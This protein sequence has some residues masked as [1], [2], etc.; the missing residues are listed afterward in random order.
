MNYFITAIAVI[1]L[2]SAGLVG[3]LYL[4]PGFLLNSMPDKKVNGQI[5]SDEV[6]DLN[7]R[8]NKFQNDLTNL[9]GIIARQSQLTENNTLY[10]ARIA[11]LEN[12]MQVIK[13]WLENKVQSNTPDIQPSPDLQANLSGASTQNFSPELFQNPEFAKL[14]QNKVEESLKSIQQKQREDMEKRISE[15]TQKAV[16]NRIEEFAKAQNLN[17]YQQQELNKI[18]S[19]RT[20]KTMELFNKERTQEITREEVRTKID[21]IR[22]ESN[23]NVKQILT[24]QQYEEYKKIENIPGGGMMGERGIPPRQG[25]K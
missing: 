8:L 11:V 20:N 2:I 10:G 17:D 18:I 5:T 22:N 6:K 21:S 19:D 7:S 24:S 1:A 3:Y 14:F 25:R 9:K 16:A 12:K 15:E 4:N 23:E 13:A